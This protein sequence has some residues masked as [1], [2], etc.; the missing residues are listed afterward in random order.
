MSKRNEQKQWLW[1]AVTSSIFHYFKKASNTTMLHHSILRLY[2][3]IHV[4]FA[5]SSERAILL[6]SLK[7]ALF[8]TFNFRR[9]N[10][11]EDLFRWI[12]RGM[13]FWR[14]LKKEMKLI[15]TFLRNCT[16]NTLIHLT[17]GDSSRPGLRYDP[18]EAPDN[19]V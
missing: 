17:P 10:S 2:K 13:Y 18:A 16:L 4:L 12:V 19:P 9:T 11:I 7:I 14:S 5:T 8:F 6:E 15:N 3:N 1:E